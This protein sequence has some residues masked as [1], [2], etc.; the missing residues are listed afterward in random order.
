MNKKTG[1]STA[2]LFSWSII[3]FLV[4]GLLLIFISQ[5]TSLDLQLHDT[6]FVIA[7]SHILILC[8]SILGFFAAFYYFFPRI[9]GRPLNEGIGKIHFYITVIGIIVI[10]ILIQY[11][12][13]L[14]VPRRYYRFDNYNPAARLEIANQW[15]A[16]ATILVFLAQLLIPVVVVYSLLKK[17]KPQY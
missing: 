11:I 9:F 16:I 2:G 5:T 10:Y 14:G 13:I 8:L 1:L 4:V 15:I 17:K 12:G 6:Y 3:I 7:Q